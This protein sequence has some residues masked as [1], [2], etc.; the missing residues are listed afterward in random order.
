MSKENSDKTENSLKNLIPFKEG[1][2]G[3]PNGRPKGVKNRSTIAKKW[4]EAVR[5][6]YN[7][8]DIPA[9]DMMMLKQIEKAM[10]GD[11][12]AAQWIYDNGYGKM[13]E[14]IK[15]DSTQTILDGD[16]MTDAERERLLKAIRRPKSTEG[17]SK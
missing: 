3:N 4:M 10:K 13:T 9:S 1:K 2:T 15:E 12:K 11:L 14:H 16:K 7:G 5:G 8:E 17:D 6:K